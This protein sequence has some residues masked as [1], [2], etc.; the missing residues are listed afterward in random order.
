MKDNHYNH[1]SF[2]R[3]SE[4][5][6]LPTMA[7]PVNYTYEAKSMKKS[8]KAPKENS[9]RCSRRVAPN[10]NSSCAS[11]IKRGSDLVTCAQRPPVSSA[12][13]IRLRFLNRLGIQKSTPSSPTLIKPGFSHR[14]SKD[15]KQDP[16][17]DNDSRT[18]RTSSFS[19]W[20]SFGSSK[21]SR[22]CLL[23]QPSHCSSHSKAR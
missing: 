12:G 7:V 3:T 23:R 21:G 22:K 18:E 19:S 15:T 17:S 1:N 5:M 8:V 11:P 4:T 13:D 6:C 14:N 16:T 9:R 20:S 10:A 2:V